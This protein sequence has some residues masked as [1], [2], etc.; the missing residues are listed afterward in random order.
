MDRSEEFGGMVGAAK[1]LQNFE[2]S[3]LLCEDVS[4]EESI[5][6]QM[7]CSSR[8]RYLVDGLLVDNERELISQTRR[9]VMGSDSKM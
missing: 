3:W 8:K 4:N 5:Q 6:E 1:V 2:V 7:G 9:R